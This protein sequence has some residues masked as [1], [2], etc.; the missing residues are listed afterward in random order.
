MD[1]ALIFVGE[2]FRR[3]CHSTCAF[4][5][6][7]FLDMDHPHWASTMPPPNQ[8]QERPVLPSVLPSTSE[9]EWLESAVRATSNGDPQKDSK[10][11]P[12]VGDKTEDSSK[13][14][15]AKQS[16]PEDIQVKGGLGPFEEAADAMGYYR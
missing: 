8:A 3:F 6:T 7:H 1:L 9:S 12:G 10:K 2:Q 11:E 4:Q 16:A 5:L 13:D 14:G 15:P